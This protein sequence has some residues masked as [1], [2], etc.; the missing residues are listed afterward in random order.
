MIFYLVAAFVIAADQLSKW[1]VRGHL[2]MGQESTVWGGLVHVLRIENNGATGNSFAGHGRWFIPVAV[3]I[4][5]IVLFYRSRG[6]L[7]GSWM[8]IGTALFVGGAI[9]N[10]ID[11]AVFDRVTDFIKVSKGSEAIMNIADIALN[12]GM[13]IIVLAMLFSRRKRVEVSPAE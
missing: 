6:K 12:A 3:L 7:K 1:W 11:R 10:A 5:A 4:L 2:E 9:G 8:E 13:I